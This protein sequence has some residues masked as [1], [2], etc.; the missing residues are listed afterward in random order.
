MENFYLQEFI[1]DIEHELEEHK[2]KPGINRE[3]QQSVKGDEFEAAQLMDKLAA[4]LEAKGKPEEAQKT[5]VRAEEM[6]AQ[7]L[8]ELDGVAR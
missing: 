7:E 1:E 3:V 8:N 5:R 6:V 4:E 2:K